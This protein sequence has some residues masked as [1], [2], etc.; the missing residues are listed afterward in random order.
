MFKNEVQWDLRGIDSIP[1]L[2]PWMPNFERTSYDSFKS[3]K[4]LQL[5]NDAIEKVIGKD[6]KIEKLKDIKKYVLEYKAYLKD[7][8]GQQF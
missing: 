7:L 3:Y 4:D 6:I 5:M 2:K 1:K 8:K